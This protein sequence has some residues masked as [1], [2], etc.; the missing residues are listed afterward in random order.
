MK[1]KYFQC[2]KNL[3]FF[4]MKKLFVILFFVNMAYA[5]V[6]FSEV[7]YNPSGSDS[8]REWIE[9]YN[10]GSS[11]NISK[12]KL[13]EQ[14]TDHGLVLYQGSDTIN[15][16]EYF[17]VASNPDDFLL[18]YPDFN[19]NLFDSVFSLS[20]TGEYLALKDDNFSLIDE[21][22][23]TDVVDEGYTLFNFNFSSWGS[24]LEEGGTPGYYDIVGNGSEGN[25]SGNSSESIVSEV[26]IGNV[27]PEILELN[28]YPDEE[29]LGGVQI[30]PGINGKNITVNALIRDN[31]SDDLN[32]NID[33]E[34]E[35]NLVS[36][37]VENN[38][39]NY[40][41]NVFME[42]HDEA[43]AYSLILN[44]DD[45]FEFVNES[46]S[47][48]YKGLMY[49]EL[50][51]SNLGFGN[52]NPGEVSGINNVNVFNKGNLDIL[53]SVSGSD[54]SSDSGTIPISSIES[55]FDA[56]KNLVN[57]FLSYSEALV[58]GVNSSKSLEFR[59]KAPVG[60]KA[61]NYTGQI[62]IIGG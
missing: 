58:K 5:N 34:K 19:G 28:I 51:K 44:V 9:F 7:M 6:I 55:F 39:S 29:E 30:F 16:D 4:S 36:L 46:I 20:N 52:V 27:K 45:E 18:D 24:S 25:S 3:R 60:V 8:G 22:N 14:R 12:W 32:V 54:L 47:F 53:L 31:N 59:F 35:V 10:N 37:E 56:W 15:N 43:K 42:S 33:F 62:N 2:A 57:G 17:V 23:Y 49:F 61:S 41:W 40:T 50:S 13:N 38:Y 1:I 48:E 21:L 11:V 26:N